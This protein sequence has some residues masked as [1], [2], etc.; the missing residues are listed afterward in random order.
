MHLRTSRLHGH[1]RRNWK[2]PPH[3]GSRATLQRCFFIYNLLF[4]CWRRPGTSGGT[5]GASVARSRAWEES[6][7][8]SLHVDEAPCKA[9]V[10]TRRDLPGRSKHRSTR[11]NGSRAIG[12]P[13]PVLA[14]RSTVR[15]LRFVFSSFG[16]KPAE[17]RSVSK[18]SKS[19]KSK[20]PRTC[21][22]VVKV[23]SDE[24]TVW[25]LV[26]CHFQLPSWQ[27]AGQAFL[28][29]V[30][31]MRSRVGVQLL[32]PSAFERLVKCRHARNDR[33]E[34]CLPRLRG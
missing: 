30:T 33:Y 7:T 34:T 9:Q 1:R 8:R 27:T 22:L 15:C 11:P 25:S 16:Y 4:P 13:W 18:L 31:K 23:E 12:L 10:L 32:G 6:G 19:S 26:A 14:N 21:S 28:V 24:I 29:Q 2:Q 17:P 5:S 3:G 20:S